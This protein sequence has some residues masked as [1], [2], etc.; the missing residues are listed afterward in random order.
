MI[1]YCNRDD[2][3]GVGK[4]MADGFE[5]FAVGADATVYFRK[6]TVAAAATFEYSVLECVDH[7]QL[8]SEANALGQHGWQLLSIEQPH[9]WWLGLFMR[10]AGERERDPEVRDRTG[11]GVLATCGGL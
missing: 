3:N 2:G 8:V 5:P 10:P 9:G 11:D 4:L 1:A 7:K 6:P